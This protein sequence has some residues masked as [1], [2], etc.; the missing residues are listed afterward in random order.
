MSGHGR[1]A[2]LVAVLAC[3]TAGAQAAAVDFRLG[4]A[5][6]EGEFGGF[7]SV[8]LEQFPAEMVVRRPTSRLT[9]SFPYVRVD[10]TGN[11]TLTADG[12]VVL[13]VGGPGRPS[14][15]TSAAGASESGPGDL[16]LRQETVL[17]KAGK[18]GKPFVSF[19]LDLKLPTA[20][21]GKGLGTGKRDWGAGLSY[22]QPL[23]KVWQILADASYRFM[24][25]PEG[26]DFQDRLRTAAGF[27]I[28]FERVAWRAIVENIPP[29]L[30]QV[31][32]F[33]PGGTPV[34]I[35]EVED[36]RTARLDLTFRSAAGGTTRLGV[37]RGLTD[38]SEDLGLFLELSSGG[39]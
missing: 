36:R 5:I 31:T 20:D 3:A 18:G 24:G 35:R 8:R 21:Q 16:L 1:G 13:G 11:V 22:V 25:D 2:I 10:R 23:G 33:D 29:V 9:L 17:L 19:G 32:V 39:R 27:A 12:P 38:S 37:S 26:I 4:A 14:Y 30:E 7:E 28:V 6:Y 15:Q 34:G